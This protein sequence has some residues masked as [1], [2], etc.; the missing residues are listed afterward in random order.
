MGQ[1]MPSRRRLL[2]LGGL[3][4]GTAV[5]VSGCGFRPLYG[6]GGGSSAV[7]DASAGVRAILASTEVALIPERSG[8]LLRRA[9]QERLGAAGAGGTTSH[10][11]RVSLLVANEP[12]GYRRDGT[13]SRVRSILTGNWLLQSRTTPPAVLAQGSERAFDAFDIPDNQ[14]FAGDAARDAMN[15]RLIQ[16]LAD[17]IVLRLSIGLRGAT[18][19]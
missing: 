9:L 4:A 16:Q 15:Q 17:D 10:E 11:L 8:Q 19:A 5:A 6:P 2:R 7:Q 3:L 1:G 18:A 13:P 12:E 14:F